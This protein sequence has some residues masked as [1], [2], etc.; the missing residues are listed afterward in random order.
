MIEN[1][2]GNLTMECDSCGKELKDAY[3]RDEFQ[4]MINAAKRSGWRIRHLGGGQ[5]AHGCPECAR[6]ATA[7]EEFS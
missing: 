6:S 1:F 2:G 3:G 7:R 4:E 5:W